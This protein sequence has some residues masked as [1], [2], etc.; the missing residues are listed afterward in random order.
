MATWTSR[1]V[2]STRHE[3]EVPA[4]PPWGAALADVESATAVAAI[5]YRK[6]HGFTEDAPIPGN[7]LQFHATDDAIV[8]SFTAER[9]ASA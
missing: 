4:A 7:A 2:T 5:H 3:W 8:I 9:P 1:T 6:I